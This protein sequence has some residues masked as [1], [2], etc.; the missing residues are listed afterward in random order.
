MMHVLLGIA[1]VASA[2]GV[3]PQHSTAS[4][5]FMITNS[6]KAELSNLGYSVRDIAS[7]EPERARAIIDRKIQ[8]P[9]QGMPQSWSRGGGGK[10]GILGAVKNAVAGGLTIAL[11]LHFSGVDLGVFSTTVDETVLVLRQTLQPP[12]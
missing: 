6:M 7:L 11:A 8:R 1:A 3:D 12:R 9:S 4:V 2:Y 5:Q 10:R